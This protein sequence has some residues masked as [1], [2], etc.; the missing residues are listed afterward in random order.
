M[1]LTATMVDEDRNAT[2]RDR[3]SWRLM[4][5]PEFPPASLDEALETPL[6][7]FAGCCIDSTCPGCG[8]TRLHAVGL[9]IRERP[10]RGDMSLCQAGAA[11]IQ[12]DHCN[13]WGRQLMLASDPQ[14]RTSKPAG[15]PP[16][17]SLTLNGPKAGAVGFTEPWWQ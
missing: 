6:R 2:F 9:L 17:W 16:N 4:P 13:R 15:G 10:L 12:C 5:A 3:A 7:V 14:W 1:Q 8:H 11:L